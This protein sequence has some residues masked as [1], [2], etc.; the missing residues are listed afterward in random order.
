[1]KTRIYKTGTFL[2]MVVVSG[3]LL[4]AGGCKKTMSSAPV[5]SNVRNYVASPGDTLLS[6]L[7]PGQWIVISGYNLKGAVGISFDGVAASF[8]DALFSDTSAAVLI[9]AVIPFPTV[10]ADQLNTITY[11]TD[12]GQTTFK[13]SIL[14]PAPTISAIS[15]ENANP[16]DT[17]TISG[18]NLFF[19]QN[20]TFAGTTITNYTTVSTGT[21][22]SFVLPSLSQ[23]GPVSLTTQSGTTTTT[24]NV[25]DVETG[26]LCNFDDVNSYS[27]GANAVTNSTTLFPDGRG[28]Y[29]QVYATNIGAN[30]FNW[31][32]GGRG[33]NLNA[34]QWVPI[35]EIGDSVSHYAVKFE[36]SVPPSWSV[37][38]LFVSANYTWT[39]LARYA[40]WLSG[41]GSSTPF[42]TD[43]W[44]TVTIPFD[45]FRTVS[46]SGVNG[47]GTSLTSFTDLLGSSGNTS[48]SIWIV[49]DAN[50]PEGTFNAAIDNIRVVKIK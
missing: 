24:Y 34:V 19:V 28:S 10:P 18:L 42:A 35:T 44:Q 14:P 17:V 43:G 36:I 29:A 22:I 13:C 3:L 33:I 20:L 5:I 47:E 39:Y 31:Y 37:G 45:S 41:S 16:G 12:H 27:W 8:N 48:L 46:S 7:A 32:N 23:S 1:M 4:I 9:P 49:N 2:M 25:N 38:T 6:A 15:N 11:V 21:S 40:P 26:M 30:D 50:A